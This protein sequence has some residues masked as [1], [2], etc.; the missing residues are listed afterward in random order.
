[1][2]Q[3]LVDDQITMGWR[4][5]LQGKL[6]KDWVDVFNEERRDEGKKDNDRI[7]VKVITAITSFT[8]NLWR[9]RCSQVFGGT[10]IHHLRKMRERLLAQVK[11]LVKDQSVRTTNGKYHIDGAPE[12]NAI[13]CDIYA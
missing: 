6:I 1:M 3:A 2:A 10:K 7:M 9:S 13:L 5:F 12:D 11:E 8:L 4:H